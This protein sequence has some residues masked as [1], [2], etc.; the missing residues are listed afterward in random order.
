MKLL[1]ICLLAAAVGHAQQ[2]T[3]YAAVTRSLTVFI[4]HE[5][6]D[7]KLPD[8]SIA[9]VDDQKIVWSQVFGATAPVLKPFMPIAISRLVARGQLELDRP[10]SDYVPEFHPRNP[11]G[12]P[13]TLRQLMSHRSGLQR[14]PPVGHAFDASSPPLQATVESLNRTELI[15]APGTHMKYSNA[16][17]AVAAYVLEKMNEQAFSKYSAT[18]LAAFLSAQFNRGLPQLDSLMPGIAALPHEKLGAVAITAVERADAVTERIAKAALRLMWAARS[19]RPL[20]DIPVTHAIPPER[21]RQLDGKYPGFE[22][23]ERNGELFALRDEGGPQLRLRELDQDLVSDDRLEFGARFYAQGKLPDVKPAPV[24]ENWTGLIGEYGWDRTVLHI[25]ERDG[26]LTALVQGYEYNPLQA[27]SA[28]VFRFPD[29][30]MYDHETL[31]FSRDGRGRAAQVSLSGVVFP[32]RRIAPEDGSTFRIVP[33]RPSAELKR[34]A[35]AAIPPHESGE[36]RQPDLVEIAKLDPT[37]RLDIRYATTNNFMSTVFYSEPRAFLQRPAAEAV[38]RAHR[39]LNALGLGLLIHDAYR[40]WY[41]TKMFWD[42]TPD[43]KKVFVA[44]PKQGSRHNRG[45]A[46]DLT[47]CDLK[48]GAPLEMTSG[49]DEFSDRSYPDYP[50]GTSLQRWNRK[51]LRRAME[52][53]GFTVY[54]A[55]WWHF[56]YRDWRFY[57]ILN[58]ILYNEK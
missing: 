54:E 36:F 58:K 17:I 8:L 12:L 46:V 16:G 47:I 56:D 42:A 24:P 27:V 33:L 2:S 55:E 25:L 3:D 30:G 21:A 1:A 28:D 34:E 6:A 40:P 41:V 45:C 9:L 51:L 48:T 4:E 44:D 38:V 7:K 19:G 31:T 10:V 32:R 13:V 26:K 29:R 49:Y 5:R 57:P 35:L 14:D 43:D 11:Y 39:K 37:I 15:Y 50:G 53:Q 18:D 22:L 20:P 52:E 23:T